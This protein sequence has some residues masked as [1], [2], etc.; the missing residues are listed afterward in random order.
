MKIQTTIKEFAEGKITFEE[1]N[2]KVGSI[3][4]DDMEDINTDPNSTVTLELMLVYFA[5]P[6]TRRLGL[7][8]IGFN[9]VLNKKKDVV[10]FNAARGLQA[11]KMLM[12]QLGF[13][14]T[15]VTRLRD[16]LDANDIKW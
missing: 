15:E 7:A 13:T 1:L 2:K 11:N 10:N 9:S 5:G 16:L 8:S 6:H 4:A 3:D 14:T 12:Q